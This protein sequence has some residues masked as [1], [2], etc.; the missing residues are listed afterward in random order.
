[1]VLPIFFPL[2]T[3]I[4][5]ASSYIIS[6]THKYKNEKN[7]DII[8]CRSSLSKFDLSLSWLSRDTASSSSLFSDQVD[9]ASDLFSLPSDSSISP[10]QS[11]SIQSLEKIIGVD[12]LSL[13]DD[14]SDCSMQ[15]HR[16]VSFN[17]TVKATTTWLS[18]SSK[19]K[20]RLWS[21]TKD[22]YSNAVRNEKEFA[23]DGSNWRTASEESEFLRCPFASSM[24]S[25]DVFVHPV[26]FDGLSPSH[27]FLQENQ[28]LFLMDSTESGTPPINSADEV[29]MDDD[30]LGIF[31]MKIT[32]LPQIL[33]LNTICATNE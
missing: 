32:L 6:L 30:L 12:Q 26:H 11:D 9:G 23:F 33:R 14:I 1:M 7:V 10:S 5:S 3:D 29:S 15:K 31:Y 24:L 16:K 17:S 25:D 27:S 18:Y 13:H 22:I 28:V 19:M 2:P 4:S 8:D 20:T 21:S